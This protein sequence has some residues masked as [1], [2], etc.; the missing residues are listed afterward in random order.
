MKNRSKE[1][2]V[3]GM[4]GLE[5]TPFDW[6]DLQGA[7]DIWFSNSDCWDWDWCPL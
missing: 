4:L 1:L 2:G 5:K 7:P 6:Y 3:Y